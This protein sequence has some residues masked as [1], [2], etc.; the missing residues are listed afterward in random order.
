MPADFDR[1]ITQGP[2]HIAVWRIAWPTMLT[3]LVAGLQG[4][5][6]HA[7]VGHFVG[8][9]GN[10]AIGVSWRI[11]SVVVVFVSAFVIGTGVLVA[12]FAGRGEAGKVN[13]VVN[14]ALLVTTL[15]GLIAFAPLGY[16]L[17]PR[18]LTM[19]HATAEVQ[20]EALPYLRTVLLFNVGL[21]LFF[22]IV[23]ALRSAGD[24]RTPLRMGIQMTTLNVVLT[25]VLVRGLGVIPALGTQGAGIATAVASGVTALTGLYLLLTR[26]LVIGLTPRFSLDWRILRQIFQIGL[27]A[28]LQVI[29]INITSVVLVRYVGSLEHSA[30]AQAA[31][32]VAYFEIFALVTWTASA[33]MTAA[34]TVAGQNLGA[35]RPERTARTPLTAVAVG[36]AVTVPLAVSFLL[37]PRWWLGLFAMNDP[38][39]QRLGVELLAFL[40]VTSVFMTVALG[41]TGALQGTGDTR[42]PLLI[43]LV[44]QVAL[45]L[46]LCAGLDH[47]SSLTAPGIWL[48][49]TTGHFV[50]CLLSVFCFRRGR[51]RR[52]EVEIPENLGDSRES[53]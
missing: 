8:F 24:A 36:L 12:R 21:L 39:V 15:L 27:P 33:V 42:N 28:G 38:Q 47:F 13:R 19:V 40:S 5:V 37:A 44:S 17:A 16:L 9:H 3:N 34:A 29:V 23:G 2:L 53:V 45:P 14:Q 22:L 43:T 26:R 52:L 7:V 51:W 6:D 48:A 1:S 32:A 49:I 46:G 50:R 10:A 20:A 25:V 31:Y 11:L 35:E 18:L 41:Y 4:L 30:Q